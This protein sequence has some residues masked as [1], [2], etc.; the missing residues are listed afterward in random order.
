M[1]IG[2]HL[3]GV[4]DVQDVEADRFTQERYQHFDTLAPQVAV[5]LQNARSYARAQRQAEREALINAISERI[6]A[7]N[8]VENALQVAVREIGRALGA[9]HTAIRLGLEHQTSDQ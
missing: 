1:V 9:Q 4:I 8:S 7:T 5:S 2:D 6:Q 3:L